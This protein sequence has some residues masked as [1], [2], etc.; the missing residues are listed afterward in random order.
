MVF[1][2]RHGVLFYEAMGLF[3]NSLIFR[4]G[5]FFCEATRFPLFSFKKH[6]PAPVIVVMIVDHAQKAVLV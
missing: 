5:V 3:R 2:M 6:C 1:A 4:F